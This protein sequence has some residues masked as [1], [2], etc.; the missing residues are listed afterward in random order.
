MSEGQVRVFT[1]AEKLSVKLRHWYY[2]THPHPAFSHLLPE[3]EGDFVLSRHKRYECHNAGFFDGVGENSLVL[4]A[5]AVSF[6]RI[7][8]ALRVHK[9]ADEISIFEINLLDSVLA[10]M[11]EF[12]LHHADFIAVAIVIHT[13]NLWLV[14]PPPLEKG[15]WG[16]FEILLIGGRF[17]NPS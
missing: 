5:S 7:N 6:W 3:G 1:Y 11:T 12:F 9:T 10:E 8:L 4:S 17:S 16:G 14:H 13:L 2:C 15:D